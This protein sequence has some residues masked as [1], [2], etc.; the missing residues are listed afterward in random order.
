MHMRCLAA[1][2][3][4][5][6]A[7]SAAAYEQTRLSH[8]RQQRIESGL[9]QVHSRS[10][11]KRMEAIIAL[12]PGEENREHPPVAD[13]RVI[14]AL[15]Q[16]LHDHAEHNRYLAAQVLGDWATPDAKAADTLAASIADPYAGN[17]GPAADALARMHDSRAVELATEV[18]RDPDERVRGWA[19]GALR[20]TNDPAAIP[21]LLSA[22]K[23]PTADV[24]D[25]VA[26][27]LADCRDPRAVMPLIEA[28]R[29]DPSVEVRANAAAAL[30]AI[31]DPRAV[32][33]LLAQ[34]HNPG[35][36]RNNVFSTREIDATALGKIGKPALPQL[37]A[38]LANPDPEVHH[39]TLLALSA[40]PD[41]S[42][43]PVMVAA[44]KSPNREDR[45]LAA[46]TLATIADP[47]ASTA[48]RKAAAAHALD[49][50]AAAYKFFIAH[51]DAAS[52]AELA[53]AL[54]ANGDLPMAQ[55]FLD[56][57]DLSLENAAE[58]W[59]HNHPGYYIS[60]AD[61]S[62]KRTIRPPCMD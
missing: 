45:I 41:S 49:A 55:A 60:P 21:P 50:V 6:A 27:A 34:L 42:V 30:G 26:D 23:D 36:P 19:V 1:F 44:L 53:E 38:E 13:P 15:T 7:V 5:A 24:R 46:A 58:T 3:F 54:T 16:A 11:E 37:K 51:R 9:A 20:D 32:G 28:L 29:S 33:P 18:L 48:L 52:N 40:I 56:T 17:H 10:A 22:L 12:D 61:A 47:A 35:P 8:D 62:G 4:F 43:T 2:I 57:G 59:A 14:S 31:R 25:R 39:Y